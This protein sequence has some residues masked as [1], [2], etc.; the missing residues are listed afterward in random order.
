MLGI[1]TSFRHEIG[2][3]V[4]EDQ[5]KNWLFHVVV[6]AGTTSKCARIDPD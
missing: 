6:R 3:K 2:L 5:R 1:R 4:V